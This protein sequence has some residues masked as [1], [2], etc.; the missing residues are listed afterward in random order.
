MTTTPQFDRYF[1]GDE[2]LQ[3]ACRGVAKAVAQTRA[4]GLTVEGYASYSCSL[5]SDAAERPSDPSKV[6]DEPLTE[7][8]GQVSNGSAPPR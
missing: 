8:A 5:K 2:L 7:G 1:F 4:A 3:D 6:H